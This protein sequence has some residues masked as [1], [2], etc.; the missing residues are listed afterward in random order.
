MCAKEL[1]RAAIGKRSCSLGTCAKELRQAPIDARS[2]SLACVA[3]NCP[4]IHRRRERMGE[5]DEHGKGPD[6]YVYQVDD[7]GA[8]RLA[9]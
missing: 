7:I 5:Y 9:Q 1:R 2:C 4:S 8:R 6:D 3:K